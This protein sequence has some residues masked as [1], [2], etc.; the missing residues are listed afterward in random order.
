MNES[1]E[2]LLHHGYAILFLSVLAEQIGLPI[3]SS[4]LLLAAGAL[5]GLQLL[6]PLFVFATA[7]G[8]SLLS[9]SAWYVLGRRRGNSILGHVC[10]ISIEPETCVSRMHTAYYRYGA[11]TLLF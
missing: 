4:P 10:Q 6:N 8:A 1:T 5:A 2:F 3:P 9:D 7:L 11:K